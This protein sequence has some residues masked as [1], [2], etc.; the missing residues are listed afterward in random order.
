MLGAW[1][2]QQGDRAYETYLST[3]DRARMQDEF[4]RA[5]RYD[6]LAVGFWVAAE[7]LLAVSVWRWLRGD[8][9][10]D[11]HVAPGGTVGGPFR[12]DADPRGE[13]RLGVSLPIPGF[14]DAEPARSA[15]ERTRRDGAS[16]NDAQADGA[17]EG[18]R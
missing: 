11:V 8:E 13:V 5:A 3:V 12:F 6:D 7:A 15:D 2:R 10:T 18:G 9:A 1:A 14:R 4:D 16:S 17:T